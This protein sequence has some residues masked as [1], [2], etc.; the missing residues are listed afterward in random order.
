MKFIYKC[1]LQN[2]FSLIPKGEILTYFFQKYVT[3]SYP[4]SDKSFIKVL[5]TAKTHFDAFIRHTRL[6]DI[7]KVTYYEFGAGWDLINPIAISLLGIHK[8]HC[9]D[10]RK[11]VF[12]ELLNNTIL[13][14]ASLKEKIPFD[15]A[16]PDGIPIAIRSNFKDILNEYFCVDYRAPMDARNTDFQDASIDFI[17]S[18]ATLEHVPKEDIAKIINECYRIMKKGGI[19]SCWIDF[20]DHWSFFDHD[21]SIYNYLKYSPAQWRKYNPSLHFQNRLRHKDYLDLIAHTDFELLEDNPNPP[22]DKE[23]D[24]L[25]NLNIDHYFLDKYTPEELAIKSSLL[26]LRK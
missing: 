23:L 25:R 26:V 22:S 13:R 15:Y 21:I 5:F 4:I 9:I 14:L 12:P 24:L 11:L 18:N 8:L 1:C 2:L 16:L 7:D 3:K 6:T 17:V 20:R 19:L 10:I